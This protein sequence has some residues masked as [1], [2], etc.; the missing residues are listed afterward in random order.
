MCTASFML[1]Q[2]YFTFEL[3]LPLLYSNSEIKVGGHDL[4]M[5]KSSHELSLVMNNW[6]MYTYNAIIRLTTRARKISVSVTDTL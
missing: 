6:S 5:C 4:S 3:E 2:F 1:I